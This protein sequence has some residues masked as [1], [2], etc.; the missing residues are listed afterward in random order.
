MP[1]CGSITNFC[2]KFICRDNDSFPVRRAQSCWRRHIP[3]LFGNFSVSARLLL[4]S[5]LFRSMRL[6]LSRVAWHRITS[7]LTPWLRRT[8]GSVAVRLGTRRRCLYCCRHKRLQSLNGIAREAGLRHPLDQPPEVSQQGVVTLKPSLLLSI[9]RIVKRF[10]AVRTL[11]TWARRLRGRG[12]LQKRCQ[13]LKEACIRLICS[14]RFCSSL[15]V[16]K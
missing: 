14:R 9:S 2:N 16:N 13:P 8:T 1:P 12:S 11:R 4:S 15:Q 3:S 10:R 7:L 6:I 5:G